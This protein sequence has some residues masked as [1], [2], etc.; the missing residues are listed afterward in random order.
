MPWNREEDPSRDFSGLKGACIGEDHP[1]VI[2]S[3]EIT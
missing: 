2:L 3:T 1:S